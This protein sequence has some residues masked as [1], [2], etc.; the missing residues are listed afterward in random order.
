MILLLTILS[1][2][3]VDPTFGDQLRILFYNAENLFDTEDNPATADEEFTPASEKHYTSHRFLEKRNMLYRAIVMENENIVYPDLIGL[4]EIENR[5][6]LESL[7]QQ[8]PLQSVPYE[9]IHRESTDPRGIDVALLYRADRMT[10]LHEAFIPL[11]NRKGEPEK[12]RETLYAKGLIDNQ[13]T[14]HLFVCHWPS[15][16]GGSKSTQLRT[17]AATALRHIVDSIGSG[18]PEA[19][20]IIM[21]DFNDTPANKALTQTLGA[22]PAG[23]TTRSRKLHRASIPASLPVLLNLSTRSNSRVPGSYKYKESWELIDQIIVSAALL[24]NKSGFSIPKNNFK[25]SSEPFLLIPDPT[26]GG[27]KPHRTYQG[28]IWKGGPSDHLPVSLLL[29]KK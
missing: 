1:L 21:G 25:I 9:I 17:C 10:L 13:D 3:P 16:L 20:I 22:L 18:H 7:L 24:K 26:H 19:K 15:K 12:S 27:V 29:H 23:F 28:P 8:T 5:H 2:L 14:L 11:T 4:A 6:V